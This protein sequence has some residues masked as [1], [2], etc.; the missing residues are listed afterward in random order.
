MWP[1]A[2]HP[3]DLA[4]KPQVALHNPRLGLH[5]HSAQPQPERNP[6]SIRAASGR[7]PRVLGVLRH[8]HAKPRRRHQRSPHHLVLQHRFAVVGEPD[9]PRLHQLVEV[10]NLAAQAAE[11]RRRHRQQLHHRAAR[12]VQ[13][14][15]QALHRIVHRSRIRHGHHGGESARRRRRRPGANR[16]LVRLPRL[17]QMH[18]DVDQP[19]RNHASRRIDP[20]RNRNAR[21]RAR[22]LHRR[23]PSIAQQHV[24]RPIGPARRIDHAPAKNQKFTHCPGL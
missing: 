5:R 11:C 21:Q 19:R 3:L 7:Q 13:H 15:A 16:L 10:R 24:A 17:A 6:P 18:M 20:L 14:P 2:L 8:R 23:N 1:R 22:L 12:R 4:Q 9:R